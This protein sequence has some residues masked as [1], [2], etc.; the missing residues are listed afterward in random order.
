MN[1]CRLIM[2][3]ALALTFVVPVSGQSQANPL[4]EQE[5]QV[6]ENTD[7]TKI[8]ERMGTPPDGMPTNPFVIPMSPDALEMLNGFAS[9][10][11]EP[12]PA[13]LEEVYRNVW[14]QVAENY[15]RVDKLANWQEWRHKYDGKLQTKEDLEKAI[16]E[17]LASLGDHWTSYTSTADEQAAMERIREGIIP[18]GISL[19]ETEDGKFVV[20]MLSFGWPAYQSALKKGDIIKQVNRVPVEGKTLEEAEA[21]VSGKIGSAL[22][23][24]ADRDGTEISV[25]LILEVPKQDAVAIDILP[26]NIGYIRFPQFDRQAFHQFRNGLIELHLRANG[27]LNGLIVDI[28]GNPGGEVELAMQFA[29][30]FMPEGVIFTKVERNGRRISRESIEVIPPMPH[31]LAEAKPEVAAAIRDYWKM[32][33]VLLVDGSSASSSEIVTGALKDNK[34]ATIIGT[35]TWGKGVGMLVGQMG[36]GGKLS[37]T[38]LT[39]R[40]PTGYDLHGKG[41]APNIE[42]DRTPGA[43]HDQQLDFAID[44]LQR[45]APDPF[46]GPDFAQGQERGIDSLIPAPV[47]QSFVVAMLLLLVVLFGYHKQIQLRRQREADEEARKKDVN[48]RY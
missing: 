25:M 31:E 20:R 5:Q 9:H 38:S 10:A 39:Y 40:T 7:G 35:T 32:P 3:L 6:E 47:W 46:T 22:H 17:M 15:I 26:G 34:R 4:L 1:I 29:E 30:T 33:L 2:M 42:V 24:L 43:T 36:I 37:V 23:V 21:M 45:Q 8:I 12:T 28:R 13:M 27:Y 44:F 48:E 19:E 18:S 11:Q 41:I 14:T 16:Q